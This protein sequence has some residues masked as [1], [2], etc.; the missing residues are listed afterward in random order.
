MLV[1]VFKEEQ[2][3]KLWKKNLD[4][5][6]TLN[7]STAAIISAAVANPNQSNIAQKSRKHIINSHAY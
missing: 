6:A 3:T 4:N 2:I 1:K 5:F 7:D